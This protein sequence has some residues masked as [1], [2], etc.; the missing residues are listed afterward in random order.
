MRIAFGCDHA[1]H[2]LKE[3]IISALE[4][5]DHHVL[6]LGTFSTDPV[7]Y[8]D[9]ARA[10]GKAVRNQFVEL[11]ILVC[12]SGVG[13]AIA[14]NKIPGVRAALCQDLFTARQSREDDD[15]NVLCLGARV[16][17]A[18][19]AIE[20]A[21]EWLATSFSGEERHVRR[22]AKI[23]ELEQG[24][25]HP[26]AERTVRRESAPRLTVPAPVKEPATP[27]ARPEPR[28][29][30]TPEEAPARPIPPPARERPAPP[31]PRPDE[32]RVD[33]DPSLAD[34]VA[35]VIEEF[36]RET[37][38]VEPRPRP[39]P[40]RPAPKAAPPTSPPPPPPPPPPLPPP[41]P[42]ERTAQMAEATLAALERSGFVE[43]LWIKDASIWSEDSAQ[44]AVI[45]NRL[46]WLTSPTLMQGHADELKEF[47]DDIRRSH[48]THALLLGMGG[49]TLCPEVLSLTFGSKMGFPDLVVLDSTDPAA[50]KAT[51]NRI[52]L[53][54]TL[55]VVSSKS[56][57]TT[58]TLAFYSFFR[59]QVERG[60]RGKPG[61]QFVAI[62][63]GGTPLEKLAKSQGFRKIF[64]NPPT[65]GGR[66]S[67]LSYFG[68]LPGAL[69]GI[70]VT[71]LLE[72]A[73]AAV[74][75]ASDSV[76]VRQ[77]PGVVL[78]AKL[79]A[80]AKAG[81]DKV[82]FVFS[83]A[84]A[85]FGAWVEQLLAESLGKNGRGLI[86]VD[87]EPLGPPTVYGSDRLFVA[88]TLAEEAVALEAGLAALEE[89][90][91][92]VIRIRLE[93]ILDLG[94]EFYRWEIATATLG[95]VL[96]VNPFDEPNVQESK[97]NTAK[98]LATYRTSRRLPEWPVDRE[99][100]G[101]ALLTGAGTKPSTVAEGL[102]AHLG[103]ARPGDY[104][105]LQAYLP[106]RPEMVEAFQ[107][108]R[109]VMRDKSKLAVTLGLG[110]RYLH[111]TGQLHKGGP[112]S[113]L[114]IQITADDPHDLPIPGETFTFAV[115]KNAQALGDL[116]ALR[117]KGRRVI[118]VHL[119]GKDPVDTLKK[120]T[121]ILA[122]VVPAR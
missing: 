106:P 83:P 21:R 122:R 86:P 102:G 91:H 8:P 104:L 24:A 67:G 71:G 10:V 95:A 32:E 85:P 103:L 29:V 76:P 52:N 4:E 49:S 79:A 19:T 43:S 39:A 20:L 33:L 59:E 96:E 2:P 93:E 116:Q 58:E 108:L 13:A 107:E 12:G 117:N 111:S 100:D 11:G 63:D 92:P 54:R 57:L 109:R 27:R 14:A 53:P 119:G 78:G 68:L 81:R 17:N 66:F 56:G 51:L 15:A 9:F 98:L 75:E 105:A 64:L 28:P 61:L 77:N 99:E 37:G 89:A 34:E 41:T 88:I 72:R 73:V 120:F 115:L 44:Q 60:S 25:L 80:W 69:V 23:V 45:R 101:I 3:P 1:G 50:I 118:R 82:T 55:F 113:A 47:A 7:D 70:D 16:L 112:P 65:I 18:E 74:E 35:K 38:V 121:A 40:V 5:D 36:D 110:P 84:L 31:P 22:L 26:T 42:A 114:I 30:P 94:R 62:T 6:D 46:G 90:G 48:Y 97:D 87:G